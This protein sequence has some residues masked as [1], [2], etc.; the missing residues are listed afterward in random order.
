MTPQ[1]LWTV[2]RAWPKAM[3]G[4]V[5]VGVGGS[6]HNACYVKPTPAGSRRVEAKG[7]LGQG[8]ATVFFVKGFFRKRRRLK[9]SAHSGKAVPVVLFSLL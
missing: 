3:R 9:G 8:I 4:G 6:L 7:G 1:R 5:G 2:G